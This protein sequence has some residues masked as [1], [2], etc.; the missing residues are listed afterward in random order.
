MFEGEEGR[1]KRMKGGCFAVKMVGSEGE[2]CFICMLSLLCV[3]VCVFLSG[4]LTR[5]YQVVL[6]CVHLIFLVALLAGSF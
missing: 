4:S 1:K 5:S 6:L 2:E 3:C